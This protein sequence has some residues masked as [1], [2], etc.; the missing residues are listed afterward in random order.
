MV[1][2]R[3]KSNPNA[4]PAPKPVPPTKRKSNASANK[5]AKAAKTDSTPNITSAKDAVTMQAVVNEPVS[6]LVAIAPV[7]ANDASVDATV[8]T[9]AMDGVTSTSTAD[10]VAAA[11]AAAAAT[12]TVAA[13]VAAAANPTEANQTTTESGPPAPTA[14]EAAT[15]PAPVDVLMVPTTEPVVASTEEPTIHT[16]TDANANANANA[17]VDATTPATVLQPYEAIVSDIEGT[18]TSIVFV[19]DTLF[20]Y[21]TSKLQDFLK[22]NWDSEEMKNAVEALR[23]QAAKDVADGIQDATLI[24]TE[25]IDASTEK[26]QED[27]MA[28]I[29]WQMKVDRK[30]GALKTFQGYM[31]KEGYANGDLKGDIYDD[32]APALEQWKAEGKKIYIYSSGSIEAQKLIFGYT[33]EG[34]LLHYFSGHFDTTVGLKV[35]ADS[36]TKIAED[37]GLTPAKILFLSDNIKEIDAAKKAGFQAVVTDRPGN[38]PL[39]AEDRASNTVVKSFLE[40][41]KPQ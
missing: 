21:V 16:N 3:S 19:K 41:P 6:D 13:A 40:I 36:Y 18:T 1:L 2:T 31:W 33:P 39:T 30:V 12:A 15:I 4:A 20:P 22:R 29:A 27:V 26:V 34:D 7:D 14:P 10:A 38:E 9:T 25:S 17:N 5:A 35:E 11:V 23:V 32:V 28:S 8:T 24:A 37:I